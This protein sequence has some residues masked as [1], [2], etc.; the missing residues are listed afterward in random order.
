VVERHLDR[1]G[2]H[3]AAEMPVASRREDR[4]AAPP[5]RIQP[6]GPGVL[7]GGMSSKTS[8]Q[9]EPVSRATRAALTECVV[10]PF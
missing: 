5:L 4:N 9:L 1:V 8:R 7:D 10:V 3:V 2:D 6:C